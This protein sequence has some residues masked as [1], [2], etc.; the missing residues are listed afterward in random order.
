MDG[1][2]GHVGVALGLAGALAA[3]VA[4]V[5]GQVLG[6]RALGATAPTY[7]AVM[8]LGGLVAAGVMEHALVAHDFSLA[9]VAANNSRETPL[10]FSVTGMWSALQGSILLWTIILSGYLAVLALRLRRRLDD[11]VVAWALVVGLAVAVFFYALMLGPADPFA[12]TPG[13]PPPDGA[14]PNPLLQDNTLIAFHP[15]FLYLGYVGFTVPFAFAVASLATGRVGEG[16]LAATRRFAL[17]AWM[18]LTVGIVLGAWWSYQVLGWG[19][20]WGW[21]PVENA[22]FLPWLTATAYLHSV[23]VQERRGL[24]RIWN[25]SLLVATFSL[26]ILGT[27]L[28]RSGV[29]QSVHAFS[30]SGIGPALL[31]LFAA[32][33]LGGVVLIGWRGDRLRAPGSIDAAA[34]REGAFLVNNLLFAGFALVVLVGTVFPL[35]VQA[36]DGQQLTIGRPYFD[37]FG[38]PIGLALLFFMAI[39]PALPWRKAAPGVLRRRLVVPAWTAVATVAACVGA[40][41]RGLAPLLAFGLAG[42]AG[43]S[44]LRQLALAAAAARRRGLSPLTGLVGRANGGMVV[45]L[46]VVVVAV[47]LAAASS[48]GQRAE[49]TLRPGQSARVDGHELTLLAVRSF[50]DP[51]RSGSEALVRVDGGGVFRPAIDTFRGDTESVGTPSIDSGALDDVYLSP[52]EI[53]PGRQV[54]TLDVVVQPLVVWL[55]IGGALVALGALLAALPGRRRRPTDPASLLFPELAEE[56]PPAVGAVR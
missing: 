20:F 45:H 2:I 50:S 43:A 44:A 24:L 46:G 15:V 4:L 12:A 22:A 17:V 3:I 36:I 31:G 29:V 32:A 55:W 19:G 14:G 35:F 7:V 28:T 6:R 34:S 40:G 42:F 54:V 52:V 27:F 48:F 10:L 41:L 9:F 11:A 39:A 49:L 30:D 38:L 33:V 25:L 8:V 13:V 56:L 53:T 37:A 5:L 51:S 23:M 21:D 26:T 16:W 1:V 47:G 18:F